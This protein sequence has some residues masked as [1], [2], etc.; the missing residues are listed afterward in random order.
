VVRARRSAS[1]RTASRGKLEKRFHARKARSGMLPCTFAILSG[2]VIV[3]VW[4]SL[5]PRGFRRSVVSCN[6]R[7]HFA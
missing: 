3:T 7:G 2:R 5:T 6:A 1:P 4:H